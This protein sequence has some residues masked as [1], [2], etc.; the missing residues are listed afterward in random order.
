MRQLS[1]H[2]CAAWVMD[3]ILSTMLAGSGWRPELFSRSQ[4]G[5]QAALG[6]KAN[7]DYA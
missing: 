3:S 4:I 7:I 5:N 2:C 1:K 6:P